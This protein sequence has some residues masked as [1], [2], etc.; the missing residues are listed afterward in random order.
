MAKEEESNAILR[1]LKKMSSSPVTPTLKTGDLQ[2]SLYNLQ[3]AVNPVEL[4]FKAIPLVGNAMY[5]SL[6]NANII[7]Q[8]LS[9]SGGGFRGDLIGLSTAAANSRLSLTEFAGVLKE[10]N[11]VFIGLGGTA[12]RGAEAFAKLSKAFMDDRSSQNLLQLGYN[13]KDLNEILA[14]QAVTL[15]GSFKDETER[16]KVAT[17][18]AAKLGQEMDLMARLT[19]KSREQQLEQ[20][21]KAQADMQFEAA[22]RLKTQ[23]MSTEEAAK[24]EANARSQYRDAE[25]R[26]Q[27]QMFKEIFA[28]GQIM[29]KE[30][31][32][33]AALMQ[34]QSA[35]TRKQALISADASIDSL[36]REQ[37][38]TAAGREARAAATADMNNKGKLQLMTLGEAGGVATKTMSEVQSA[39]MSYIRGLEAIKAEE[40]KRLGRT[41]SYEEAQ[42]KQIEK[43]LQEAAGRNDAGK[44]VNELNKSMILFE[45]RAKDVSAALNESLLQPLRNLDG[46]FLKFNTM[47]SEA[48]S[49]FGGTNKNVR[50]AIADTTQAAR[51]GKPLGEVTGL[52]GDVL[53]GLHAGA[54]VIE[55]GTKKGAEYIEKAGDFFGRVT[56][57]GFQ[58]LMK[59]LSTEVEAI[60][61]AIK[62]GAVKAKETLEEP[63]KLIHKYIIEPLAKSAAQNVEKR[64][65]GS[66]EMT[67]KLF[68]NWGQGTLVELH[69]MEGVVKPEEMA[70]IA[71]GMADK[72]AA[73]A[74]DQF[75]NQIS[76]MKT[77]EPNKIDM[78]K[79]SKDINVSVSS[80]EKVTGG[81]TVTNPK[82]NITDVREINAQL[83]KLKDDYGEKV[84]DIKGKIREDLG[85]GATFQDKQNAL[86]NNEQFKALKSAVEEQE[87]ILN[88][89]KDAIKAEAEVRKQKLNE[90]K[91]Y[92][93]QELKITRDNKAV[94]Q[95]VLKTS[96]GDE[97]KEAKIKADELKAVIGKSVSGMSDDQIEKMLPKGSTVDDFFIDMQGKL[98]SF[99]DPN[100]LSKD[101]KS[102]NLELKAEQDYNKHW[103]KSRDE[104]AKIVIELEEK[105]ASQTLSKREQNELRHQ[106][107]LKQEA[108]REVSISTANIENYKKQAEAEAKVTDVFFKQT[109]EVQLRGQGQ[110]LKE[111]FLTGQVLSKEAAKQNLTSNTDLTTQT[112]DI[113]N[114]ILNFVTST[115]DALISEV[116]HIQ[117][118]VKNAMSGIDFTPI[119]VEDLLKQTRD[120]LMLEANEMAED[121]NENFS[122][123]IDDANYSAG[124]GDA[125][126]AGL[127][128]IA[129]DIK[130]ALPVD[131]FSGLA[132]AI[133]LQKNIEKNT[134]GMDVRAEDGTV[135]KGV[136]INPETGEKYY[137]DLPKDT[138]SRINEQ[139]QTTNPF[140]DDKGNINLNSIKLPGMKQ[141]GADL[142]TQT[143]AVA[144]KNDENQS[145]AETARLQRQ[146]EAAKQSDSAKSET[147]GTETTDTKDASLNDVVKGLTVLNKSIQ[148]LIGQNEKLFID[149]IRATKANNRNNFIGT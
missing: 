2:D 50:A 39:N 21:K 89:Q 9:K 59:N 109:N 73:K 146:N 12:T 80:I 85:A 74:I 105:A 32:T 126:I 124:P 83:K 68:E 56:Q 114:K 14:I 47:L 69:G 107:L 42:K 113:F 41:V 118:D 103:I 63:L 70:N 24:F 35:A 84:K 135:S 25:L 143:A 22:I 131:E 91:A 112:K 100:K 128:F 133:E 55:Q 27:G 98:Q 122:S 4:A 99:L 121:I 139:V 29:S 53:K 40:E 57:G 72:G 66:L 125:S 108:D 147:K 95:Q 90:T 87:A 79:I 137:T 94:L 37:E 102:Y 58:G 110:M 129:E 13:A 97:I 17:E 36:K 123:M 77:N 67:G 104:A 82:E 19:G 120:N 76:G 10:N 18:N 92:V 88:R 26:G 142:K 15:R 141:F 116:E 61:P 38:A 7:F 23:G 115:K 71:K 145:D 106:Q 16:N 60:P 64:Q 5:T 52:G 48:G 132:E 6:S 46:P 44:S 96:T 49:N 51:E 149:Q 119:Q 138:K 28:T 33:Q 78:S 81:Q 117:L 144:K 127:D 134:S 111:I 75:K 8:D 54:N 86:N 20:M 31:A 45:A 43:A 34:E 1:Y 136:K 130:K 3:K 62:E 11:E 148:E 65:G 30:A 101:S 140:F 93:E